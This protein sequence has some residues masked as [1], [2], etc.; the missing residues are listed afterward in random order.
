MGLDIGAYTDSTGLAEDGTVPAHSLPPDPC[1][2]NGQVASEY[3]ARY[4]HPELYK[5]INFAA[6]LANWVLSHLI[7]DNE[8]TFPKREEPWYQPNEGMFPNEEDGGG[9]HLSRFG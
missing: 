9:N 5:E 6:H 3:G 8:S 4:N 1:D 7:R 2:T